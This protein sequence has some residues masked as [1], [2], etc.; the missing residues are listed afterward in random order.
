MEP[1][2]SIIM[3]AY[4]SEKFIGAAIESILDQTFRE[5]ELLIIEDA[6][7]DGTLKKYNLIRIHVFVF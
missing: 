5:F 7:T 6:S 1:L 2:V 4:N 3:A